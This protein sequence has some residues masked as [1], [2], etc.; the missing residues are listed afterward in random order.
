VIP[1]YDAHNHFQDDWL[2][3]HR[4][5]LDSELR[6]AGLRRAVVNGTAEQ[7]WPDVQAV[8]RQFDWVVPSFG[9][10]PW[11]VGNR[12]PGWQASLEAALA[13]N[14]GAKVGEIGLDRWI[15]DRAKP[16]DPRLAG[17]RRAPLGEQTEV[18][19][20]QLALAARRNLAAS[21]HCLDAFGPM[22]DVLKATPRPAAGFLLHAY[23][24]PAEMVKPF[25]DLGA[26]F[27][28]N[29]SFLDARHAAKQEVFKKI[30][31]DRL[32]VE[33]DAPAMRLPPAREKFRP[34][35]TPSGAV[36]NHP[37]NIAAAYAGLA[38]LRGMSL[39]G[40]AD[41]VEANFQRLFG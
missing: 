30:P 36:A 21:I 33:T 28:F 16:D 37:G 4:A 39:D 3:P 9:L 38:E 6:S 31:V 18:F 27:S 23:S 7:D 5:S 25:A 24:G 29:G 35:S 19:A 11:D 20:W 41:Q 2:A 14:A 22:L 13:A 12:T 15:L 26:Y 34:L 10:H 8:A 32:L 17:L 1:L 40:L